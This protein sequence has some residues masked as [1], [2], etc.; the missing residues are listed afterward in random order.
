MRALLLSLVAGCAAATAAGPAMP[1]DAPVV[2][3]LF[4]GLGARV[5]GR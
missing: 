1:D 3:E 5:L 4:T 2:I